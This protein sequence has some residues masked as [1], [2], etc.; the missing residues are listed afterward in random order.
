MEI[1]K[2][3]APFHLIF[4]HSK[5]PENLFLSKLCPCHLWFPCSPNFPIPFLISTGEKEPWISVFHQ[6]HLI[7]TENRVHCHSIFTGN[8]PLVYDFQ[9]YGFDFRSFGF[10][11]NQWV[12]DSPTTLRS[13]WFSLSVQRHWQQE[14]L[15]CSKL[16]FIKRGKILTFHPYTI[17]SACEILG[18]ECS[19]RRWLSKEK[20]RVWVYT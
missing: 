9:L 11:F 8:T 18:L 15:I 17:K 1:T 14:S 19:S 13:I 4:P 7:V 3:W 16:L 5:V 20:A 6:G 12:G 10:Y 2:F